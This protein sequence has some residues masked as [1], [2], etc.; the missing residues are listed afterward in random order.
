[1]GILKIYRYP[2]DVLR[3]ENSPVEQFD[4]ELRNTVADMYETM[5]AAEGIGLAGPQVGLNKQIVVI[6]YQG[7]KY[8][9]IN[10]EILESEGSETHEEGCLSFPGIFV[11]VDSPTS[12]TVRYADEFGKIYT[13]KTEGFLTTVFSHEIDHLH[14]RMLIDRVSPLKRT[15]LKKKLAKNRES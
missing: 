4:D 14:G 1:M 5:Y 3:A 2:D 15:I 10:P 12:M 8:T 11:K 7:D 6:D 13:K 9:L